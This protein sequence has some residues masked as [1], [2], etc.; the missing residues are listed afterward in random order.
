MADLLT[1][2]V[3]AIKGA[4]NAVNIVEQLQIIG[5]YAKT[6][7]AIGNIGI[8]LSNLY[9]DHVVEGKEISSS[10]I[11]NVVSLGLSLITLIGVNTRNV[12]AEDV[13][14][15]IEDTAAGDT[16]AVRKFISGLSDDLDNYDYNKSN[17]VVEGI[18]SGSS[19]V[20][21]NDVLDSP[22]TGSALKVD[23]VSPIYEINEKTGRPQ[24]VKEFPAS[25]QA[26]GFNDIIDNYAGYATKTSLNNA[27]LYQLDGSLNGVSGRFEWIIQDG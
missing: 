2:G 20:I 8:A 9:Q 27:T 10:T 17:K 4:E 26:H 13:V 23:D 15:V 14:D 3:K 6:G 19:S 21:H 1:K 18:E 24:I 7:E 5:K 22:R 11:L 16:T 25:A 12:K